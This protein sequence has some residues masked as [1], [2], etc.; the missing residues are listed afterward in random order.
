MRC[1]SGYTKMMQLLAFLALL[2]IRATLITILDAFKKWEKIGVDCS[3]VS[4]CLPV[5]DSHLPKHITFK[6]PHPQQP[7]LP[8]SPKLHGQSNKKNLPPAKIFCHTQCPLIEV[9][10][11]VFFQQTAR[12][13]HTRKKF[14]CKSDRD[15]DSTV[16]PC[17]AAEFSAS[18]QHCWHQHPSK[19][20]LCY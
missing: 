13:K 4:S 7:V 15:P 5:R 16:T 3:Q 20:Y 12:Q 2:N 1:G 14:F 8:T 19:S 17:D 18:W 10:L 11:K 6:S 9:Y